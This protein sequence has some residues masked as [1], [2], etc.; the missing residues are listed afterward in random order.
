MPVV[1]P[2]ATITPHFRDF[3]PE[4]VARQSWYR[5]SGLPPLRMV[6]AIRFEDPAGEVGIETHLVA[7]GETLYQVPMT[8]RGAALA[9][10]TL[11]ATTEH[12]VLGSRW[13]Y[14]GATDPVWAA[15]LIRLIVEEDVSEPSG[16]RGIASAQARGL[17]RRPHDSVPSMALTIDLRR[18]LTAGPAPDDAGIVGVAMGSWQPA[19]GPPDA[20]VDG[21]L[22]VIR[23]T[24]R[25]A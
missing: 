20:R 5:G 1:Y 17:L 25:R 14:D 12:S 8:Y 19:G 21:C 9:G 13:I 3:L 2:G 7:D 22:A 23:E 10:A 16:R 15:E 24:R 18:V 6:G 11:I 4:W